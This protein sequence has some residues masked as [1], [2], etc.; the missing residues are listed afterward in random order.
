MDLTTISR[1]WRCGRRQSARATTS[2]PG[3]E[4]S[5]APGVAARLVL[6]GRTLDQPGA[7]AAVRSPATRGDGAD[8]R[9]LLPGSAVTLR[10]ATDGSSWRRRQGLEVPTRPW[11]Q[12]AST[13]SR[14]RLNKPGIP[15]PVLA[16][17]ELKPL[18]IPLGKEPMG[19]VILV[20]KKPELAPLLNEPPVAVL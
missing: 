1:D 9:R 19:P 16:K 12:L 4:S 6:L 18:I 10:C 8:R 15:M 3:C 20:L 17:P 2:E 14:A 13:A 11:G 5:S 7:D